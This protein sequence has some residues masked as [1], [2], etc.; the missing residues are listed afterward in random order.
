MGI[1]I[2]TVEIVDLNNYIPEYYNCPNCG[3][4]IEKHI[5]QA[6]AR[7]HVNAWE[8]QGMHCSE[9]DCVINHRCERKNLEDNLKAD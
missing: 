9:K 5:I 4:R 6:G 1:I 7:Y 2:K 3:K 8:T